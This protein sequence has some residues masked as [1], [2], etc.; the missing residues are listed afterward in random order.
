MDVQSKIFVKK[1]FL[2]LGVTLCQNS[3]IVSTENY[4]RRSTRQ[5]QCQGSA[6]VSLFTF[7]EVRVKVGYYYYTRQSILGS[8]YLMNY[9]PGRE[10]RESLERAE[11]ELRKQ[12]KDLPQNEL[13]A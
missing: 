12:L 1:Y 3:E 2:H 7:G 4:C 6:K 8:V 13:W 5:T 11:R 10:L 9:E